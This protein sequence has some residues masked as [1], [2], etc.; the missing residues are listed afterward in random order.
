MISEKGKKDKRIEI[1]VSE[2]EFEL[3]RRA[4]AISGD[5]TFSSF[6]TR[7][8]YEE[9]KNIIAENERFLESERDREVFFEAIFGDTDTEP[10][11]NLVKASQRYFKIFGKSENR[12]VRETPHQ[13]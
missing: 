3:F 13:K 8:M 2:Y 7:I 9:S 6:F 11:E 10:N 4:Q 12:K 5:N 1:R